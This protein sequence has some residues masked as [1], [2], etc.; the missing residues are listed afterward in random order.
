[1][2]TATVSLMLSVIIIILGATSASAARAYIRD[3]NKVCAWQYPGSV[4]ELYGR[5]VYDWK[6]LFKKTGVTKS[7]S[8][9]RY[10][11]AKYGSNANTS[12]DSEYLPYSWYCTY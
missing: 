5:T 9:Y 3:M 8:V 4:G 7:L 1:M 11:Q 10:C 2:K 12:F 6:C